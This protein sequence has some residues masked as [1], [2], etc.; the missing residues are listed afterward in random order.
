MQQELGG[1]VSTDIIDDGVAHHVHGLIRDA[2]RQVPSL[3]DHYVEKS[4]RTPEQVYELAAS[5]PSV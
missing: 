4:T 2:H 1:Q 5:M 3:D